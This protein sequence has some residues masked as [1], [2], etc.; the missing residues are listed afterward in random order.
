MSKLRWPESD[1]S[2][3]MQSTAVQ[4][5]DG[6]GKEVEVAKHGVNNIDVRE[7]STNR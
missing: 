4:V 7:E 6:T 5:S 3:R 1:V 2:S